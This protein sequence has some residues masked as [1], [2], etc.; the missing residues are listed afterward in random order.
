[1]RRSQADWTNRSLAAFGKLQ[2]IRSDTPAGGRPW[3][4]F[5]HVRRT[6]EAVLMG[7]LDGG[8]GGLVGAVG[9]F[10]LILDLREGRSR[11]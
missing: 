6:L 2:H 11:G 9:F 5:R 8:V 1:M 10:L 7:V 3:F 4:P